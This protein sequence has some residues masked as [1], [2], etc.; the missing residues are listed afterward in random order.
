MTVQIL[1]LDEIEPCRRASDRI[2]TEPLDHLLG[3]HDLV[4]AVAPA[5]PDE[6][7]AERR[8]QIAHGAIGIDPERAM[9]LGEFG[10]VRAMNQRHMCEDRRFPAER[11]VDLTLA[12]GV[13]EMIVAA[14]DVGD[15]HVMVV[16]HHR[17]I[18]SRRAVASEDHEIVEF[19]VGEH[20]AALHAILDHRLA[21]ARRLEADGGLDA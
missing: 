11:L 16:D 20:D 6:I 14:D 8:R 12:G 21:L 10:T 5:E 2:E 4:V 7:V 1:E 18:I 3:R 13:G 19:L 15:G 9:T 17:Q